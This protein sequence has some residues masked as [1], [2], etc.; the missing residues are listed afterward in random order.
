METNLSYASQAGFSW[1]DAKKASECTRIPDLFPVAGCAFSEGLCIHTYTCTVHTCIPMYIHT[2][3][4]VHRMKCL[5]RYMHIQSCMCI[6]ICICI[7]NRFQNTHIPIHL[8][9]RHIYVY[10]C[11]IR[12]RPAP[13]SPQWLPPHWLVFFVLNDDG[14]GLYPFPTCG[15]VEGFGVEE[16]HSLVWWL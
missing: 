7:L 11:M 15:V 1:Q 9:Y 6:Y 4:Y 14:F 16:H 12:V 10:I 3:K 13:P 5:Y 2:Y 8:I